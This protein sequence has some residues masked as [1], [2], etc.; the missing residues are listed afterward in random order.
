M[1]RLSPEDIWSHHNGSLLM[2]KCPSCGV[3]VLERDAVD[4]KRN[5]VRGHI[6][7]AKNLGPDILENVR[8][9][10]LHCNKEDKK[11]NL[12]SNYHYMVKLRRMTSQEADRACDA[13]MKL[14]DER[15]KNPHLDQCIARKQDGKWC[16]FKKKPHSAYCEVHR[17]ANDALVLLLAKEHF[18]R[19]V[20]KLMKRIEVAK[21][22]DDWEAVEVLKEYGRGLKAIH[23]GK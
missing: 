5:W 18:Q 4:K 14:Y 19:E 3:D 20:L 17:K 21:K 7:H 23:A 22:L 12:Y 10:C 8:P 11:H 16:T 6:I 15:R 9:I 1:S 13:I 2:V